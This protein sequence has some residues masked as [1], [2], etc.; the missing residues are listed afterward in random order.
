VTKQ[1]HPTASDHPWE[2]IYSQE[3][4]VFTEHLP[5]L[6]EVAQRFQAESCHTVL[7]LGCG[8][9]RHVV[10]LAGMGFQVIGLDISLTGLKL[11]QQWLEESQQQAALVQSDS[12]HPLP[13]AENCLDGLLSTQVIH[14]AL[15]DEVLLAISEIYRVLKPGGSAFVTV[16][17]RSRSQRRS[18]SQQIEEYTFLPLEGQEAGLPHHIFSEERLR[19]AF[20]AFEILEVSDRDNGRILAIWVQKSA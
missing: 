10:A 14:H 18:N 9:G 1:H 12:R 17:C 4:R 5:A 20:K 2:K 3:G 11:S 16:P 19:E 15:Q 7:D 8:N 13:L 6:D